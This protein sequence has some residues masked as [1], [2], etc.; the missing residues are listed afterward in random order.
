MD[1]EELNEQLCSFLDHMRKINASDLYLVGGHPPVFRVNDVSYPA[2]VPLEVDDIASMSES[3]L[4]ADQR[5]KGA[6]TAEQAVT[7]PWFD[8]R[9]RASLFSQ[10]GSPAIVVR[11]LA[12][13]RPID[14]LGPRPELRQLA[15]GREGLVLVAGGKRSGRTTTL[16]SMIDHRNESGPG[17]IVTIEDPIEVLH[18]HKQCVVTQRAIG[19]DTLSYAAALRAAPSLA[20]DLVYVDEIRDAETMDALLGLADAGYACCASLQAHSPSQAVDRVLGFFSHERQTEIRVRLA[21]ALRAVVFQ[22]LI[23]SGPDTRSA[24]FELLLDTPETR[25]LI[26]RGDIDMLARSAE[27]ARPGSA[28]D[29]AA[30]PLRLAPDPY[31]R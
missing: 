31:D 16:A 6:A 4:L 26:R 14:E 19:V 8:D 12:R 18:A 22:R 20:P 17:H 1:T 27:G 28:S 9:F 5:D 23:P 30:V 21:R 7:F 10:R 25:E 15:L 3:L 11:R 29:R 2:R 13:H 24:A